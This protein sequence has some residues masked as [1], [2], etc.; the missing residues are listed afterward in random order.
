MARGKWQIEGRVIAPH[1][2]R[3]KCGAIY[4]DHQGMEIETSQVSKLAVIC[5]PSENVVRWMR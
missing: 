4:S 3:K 2:R 5:V 1:F